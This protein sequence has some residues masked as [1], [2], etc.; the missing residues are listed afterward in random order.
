[1]STFRTECGSWCALGLAVVSALLVP[2]QSPA[3]VMAESADW[4]LSNVAWTNAIV[5]E[6][7]E[8]SDRTRQSRRDTRGG[9]FVFSSSTE[10]IAVDEDVDENFTPLLVAGDWTPRM[11]PLFARAESTNSSL[12][13][14][15]F[16]WAT[17]NGRYAWA[18]RILTDA[19]TDSLRRDWPVI[20]APKVAGLIWG[21]EE[22]GQDAGLQRGLESLNWIDSDLARLPRPLVSTNALPLPS[23]DVRSDDGVPR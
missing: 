10:P 22:S 15:A 8:A 20:T 18:Y 5:T 21:D 11:I 13:D 7:A 19:M 4:P 9:W 12:E 3:D 6:S 16:Q 1:M 17:V 2:L 14:L 23:T